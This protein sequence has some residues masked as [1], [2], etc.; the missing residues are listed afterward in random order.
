MENIALA[1]Y[2]DEVGQELLMF[3]KENSTAIYR[4]LHYVEENFDN[5]FQG[6]KVDY[7]VRALGSNETSN[8]NQNTPLCIILKP[9]IVLFV[10]SSPHSSTVCICLR[11]DLFGN[12]TLSFILLLACFETFILY[13]FVFDTA[14]ESEATRLSK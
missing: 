4:W 6:I 3:K 12:P 8:T 9:S 2:R 7:I 13:P 10:T 14:A 11:C 1:Y 5:I